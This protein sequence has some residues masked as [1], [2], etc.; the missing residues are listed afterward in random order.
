MATPSA[1]PG[2]ASVMYMSKVPT[3]APSARNQSVAG[4]VTPALACPALNMTPS[5]S[6]YMARS[7]MIGRS[8]VSDVTTPDTLPQASC[9]S[10]P[11]T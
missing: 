9:A 2:L 7:T 1:A 8:G 5:L 4:A 3:V 6:W 11:F 10:S